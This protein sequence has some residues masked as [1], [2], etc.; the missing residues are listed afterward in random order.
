MRMPLYFSSNDSE[1]RVPIWRNIATKINPEVLFFFQ[2]F[3]NDNWIKKLYKFLY[4][5]F[6]KP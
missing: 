2:I 4:G 5:N 3:V 1:E 6:L